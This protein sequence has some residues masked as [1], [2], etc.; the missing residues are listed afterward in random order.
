MSKELDKVIITITEDNKF[1]INGYDPV[2]I[3]KTIDIKIEKM[4]KAYDY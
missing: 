1:S 4:W 2:V 3:T